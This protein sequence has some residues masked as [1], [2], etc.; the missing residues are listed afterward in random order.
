MENVCVIGLGYVGLTLAV[1]LARHGKRVHG[2]E[3]SENVLSALKSGRAHFYEADFDPELTAAIEDSSFTFSKDFPKFETPTTYIV[4][5]GTP[6]TED[7]TVNLASLNGVLDNILDNLKEN[8][9]VILRSTVKLGV[10]RNVVKRKLDTKGIQYNLGF[11]PERTLEGSAFE[12]LA[13]LPQVISGVDSK[14]LKT[15]KSF[16]KPVCSETV[17]LSS[18]EEAEMVKLLNNSERDLNFALA[19]EVALMSEE[20]GLNAHT[21]ISA[22]NYKY[23]RSNIKKPGPVGG[24]CLEKDPYIL[25]EGF[26]N[27][28]Y[29]PSLFL[30]SRKV[31][32]SI[33][34]VGI[35]NLFQDLKKQDA[36]SP[37]KIAV[38]GFAFKGAPPTG[39]TRGSL[40]KQLISQISFYFPDAEIVG[41]DYLADKD[42]IISAGADRHIE[43]LNDSLKDT[44]IVIIQNNHPS[45][46]KED[47]RHISG[48]LTPGAFI[49]DFWNQLESSRFQ[50]SIIYRI[51][52]VR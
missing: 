18:L 44:D 10:T 32:E 3:I 12:E 35:K 36:K 39:D 25:T 31:N 52:G 51:F 6:L 27:K 2:V 37:K 33:I 34:N 1:Y 26:S 42:D 46:A 22:A 24:P 50:N 30:A 15:I 47:W 7:G 5:V 8:D 14:S 43:S 17:D 9:T 29:T 4:T 49:Y 19:N 11:C 21:I 13:S 40:V 16:F 28:D 48:I 23:P 45:Y 20:L 38:L 41:H